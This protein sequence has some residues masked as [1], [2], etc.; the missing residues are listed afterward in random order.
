MVMDF[1]EAQRRAR[2]LTTLY[3]TIF[4]LL[5]IVVAIGAEFA[6]RALAEED[7]NPSFPFVGSLFLLVTFSVA[8][9]EYLMYRANGG[10]YV[11]RAVG[12]RLVDPQTR[13]FKEQQLLNIV[14]EMALAASIPVPPVYILD[15]SQSINAFAAGL[16]HQDAIITV[17]RGSL[18]SLTRDELQGVVAHELGHIHNGDMRISM[19]L[20]AMIMGFFFILYIGLR[21]FQFAPMR[22]D[23]SGRGGGGNA[24]LIISLVFFV[25]GII[26]W[27][28]GTILKACV[29]RQ[30]EYL[31]DASAV[32]FTRHPEGIANALIKIGKEEVHDMPG[33]GL[34]YSHMYLNDDSFLSSLF[35]THPSLKKRIAAL[36]GGQYQSNINGSQ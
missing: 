25:A 28:F 2:R 24:I 15:S 8:G 13:D 10:S 36:L 9:F 27:F 16:T 5:A 19:R 31:A 17:T 11:A 33:S 3:M 7:Y 1:W 23:E 21:M 34:A 26:T 12:A 18:Q 29:S 32:Q 14:Q 30:R 20:A 22:R 4:I 35:A 6:V